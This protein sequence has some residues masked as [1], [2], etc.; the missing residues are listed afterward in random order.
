VIHVL[1]DKI[2]RLSVIPPSAIPPTITA[3]VIVVVPTI[4]SPFSSILPNIPAFAG[5]GSAVSS[6]F[7]ATSAPTNITTQFVPSC[8][9]LLAIPAEITS[10]IAPIRG[11]R[12]GK[13]Q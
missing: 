6:Y 4:V 10:S 1:S 3:S 12:R 9:K 8:R 11:R 5:D 7:A 13:G 2:P